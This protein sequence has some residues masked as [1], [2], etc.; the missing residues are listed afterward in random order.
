MIVEDNIDGYEYYCRMLQKIPDATY[1]CTMARDGITG[2]QF[3]DA[4]QF[5]CVLVDYSIPGMDGLELLQNIRINDPFKPVILLTG[6]GGE[7][8]AAEAIKRGA[9]DYLRKSVANK[10]HMHNAIVTA[11]DLSAAARNAA[12]PASLSLLFVD[13]SQDDRQQYIRSLQKT[14]HTTYHVAEVGDGRAAVKRIDAESF[15]CV[16]FEYLLPDMDGLE[17]MKQ[18]RSRYFRR[19]P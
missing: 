7:A 6:H 12:E 2:L 13:D 16:L 18:I 11:I 14:S 5:D 17:V 9:N 10:E 4:L 1:H 8:V 15:D 3:L 19:K